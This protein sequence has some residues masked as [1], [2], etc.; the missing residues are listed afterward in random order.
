MS[1]IRP[2]VFGDYAVSCYVLR[3]IKGQADT[4]ASLPI[5]LFLS[6]YSVPCENLI[7]SL[8]FR[9]VPTGSAHDKT[10]TQVKIRTKQGIK[11]GQLLPAA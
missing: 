4:E 9:G 5:F 6:V 3:L 7:F 11:I 10:N 1:E 2:L 8:G